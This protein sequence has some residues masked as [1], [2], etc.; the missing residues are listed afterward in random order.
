M[1][2]FLITLTLVLISFSTLNAE[3]I[4]NG[5]FIYELVSDEKETFI[6]GLTDGIESLSHPIFPYEVEFSGVIYLII[7]IS[8]NAFL[9]IKAKWTTEQSCR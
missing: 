4:N 2:N 3:T 9:Y 1:K 6:V 7:G 8:Q 5:S